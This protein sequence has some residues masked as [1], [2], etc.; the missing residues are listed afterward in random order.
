M[1][2]NTKIK[3]QMG[4]TE[5]LAELHPAISWRSTVAGLIVS[6]FVFTLLMSLGVAIGGV[7]LSDGAS[8]RNS[9]IL[10]GLW[11]VFSVILSV[12]TGSYLAARVSHFVSPLIGIA[13]GAVLASLFMGF[14]LWQLAGFAGW[15]ARSA[16]SLIGGAAQVG[17]PLVQTA[18]QN[19]N[20][21]EIVE[22]SMTGVQF[23]NDPSIVARGVAA[24]L[25]RGEPDSAKLYLTRN[26]NLS[27]AEV[28]TRIAQLDTQI[29]QTTE[30][31]RVAAA[32]ALKI[33]GWSLFTTL[34]LSM[35]GGLL[36]GVLGSQINQKLPIEQADLPP[37]VKEK[38][39]FT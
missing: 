3:S 35:V 12:F 22:D 25:L 38:L 10:G 11:I 29:K 21:S 2:S 13:Q 6:L 27:S 36:G 17:A 4:P 20:V 39:A 1:D 32:R 23:K 15:M 31:A 37:A 34:L 16:G 30:E 33:T 26:T 24:R 18:A 7:S 8:F 5:F 9:G 28:D 19:L 14:V